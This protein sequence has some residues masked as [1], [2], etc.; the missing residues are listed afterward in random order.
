MTL[1]GWLHWLTP[2]WGRRKRL[3]ELREAVAAQRTVLPVA[4]AQLA[5]AGTQIEQAVAAVGANFS[6]MVREAKQTVSEATRLLGGGHAEAQ[7][8]AGVESA[9][10]TSRATLEDLLAR[11]VQDGQTCHSLVD[12]MQRLER[13]MGAILKSLGDVDQIAFATTILALNAK[14]EAAHMGDR[15]QGFEIVAQEMSS[16]AHRSEAIT[17]TIRDTILRLSGDSQAVRSELAAL[18]CA[19]R[20]NVASL[21]EN[22]S[23]AMGVL[24]QAHGEMKESLSG[25]AERGESLA[26]E[27]SQAVMMLQFQDR[28]NQQLVHV[29]EALESMQA[30]VAPRLAALG[31]GVND[32]LAETQLAGSYTMASERRVH[33]AVLGQSEVAASDEGDIELF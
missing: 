9:L 4:R 18:T 19:D 27:I 29:A 14:I 23:R 10:S 5:D 8:G 26:R 32:A 30:G 13:D 28:V 6:N 21:Q 15:G 25:A 16:Q 17:A 1:R 7:S 3:E 12:R 31:D 33:A 11:I 24:E 2:G 20:G 22:V